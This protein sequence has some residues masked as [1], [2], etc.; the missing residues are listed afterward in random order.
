MYPSR[1]RSRSIAAAALLAAITLACATV[2]CA[3]PSGVG[4]DSARAFLPEAP[5]DVSIHDRATGRALPLWRHQGELYVAGEP[6]REY[7][8]RLRGV[9][10]RR[11]LAV[12]SVDGVNVLTG[13][14]AALDQPGYVIDGWSAGV[15]DGWR[16]SLDEVAAFVFTT[17]RR[18]YATR[19]GRPDD[20]GVIGVAMFVERAS[21]LERRKE[22]LA[23][24]RANERAALADAA[25]G[26]AAR[27]SSAPAAAPPHIRYLIARKNRGTPIFLF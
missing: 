20:V 10:A 18:S 6:E 8:I 16:K 9:A 4:A 14:S 12:T 15:I 17:P 25:A 5:L 21:A 23:A 27:E 22:Q 7:E 26:A 24:D 3:H 2:A 13:Q 11:V 19:T 1:I